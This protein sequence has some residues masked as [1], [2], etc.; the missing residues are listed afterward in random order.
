MV[1]VCAAVLVAGL[2]CVAVPMACAG[3][4]A[5]PPPSNTSAASG[6]P[7]WKQIYENG[8][9]IYYVDAAHIPLTSQSDV[10]A[11]LEFKIPQV[12]NGAQVWSVVSR[13][14]L[15]CDQKRMITVDNT[16]YAQRMGAG[17]VV[18]SQAANDTWHQP[19]PGSLGELIW[20]T[21]C[22]AK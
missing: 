5:S 17:R 18:Q 11:L 4:I 2:L 8:Q 15:S 9:T 1:K 19:E 16:L 20:S 22:G 3:T 13:M 21:A 14:T 12:A 7:V 6:G 10:E